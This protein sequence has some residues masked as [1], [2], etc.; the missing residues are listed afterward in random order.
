[1]E[2]QYGVAYEHAH[3]CCILL[4]RRTRFFRNGTWHTWI[5]Y[6]RFHVRPSLP[7]MRCPL[8]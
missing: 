3:S 4:A 1:M 6:D 7:V 8:P 2:G 5:N